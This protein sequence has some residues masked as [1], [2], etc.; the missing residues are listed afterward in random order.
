LIRLNQSAGL[1]WYVITINYL[2]D[3]KVRTQTIRPHFGVWLL[4]AVIVIG[5]LMATA[6]PVARVPSP[7]IN[8]QSEAIQPK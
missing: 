1:E 4:L 2:E 8:S 7:E 6:K 5:F 3:F